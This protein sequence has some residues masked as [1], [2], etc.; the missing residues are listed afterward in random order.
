MPEILILEFAG[1]GEDVYHAVNAQLGIDPA[2]RTGDLPAGLRHHQAGTTA[3]G[4]LVV[5]E[6]WDSQEANT[7]FMESRLGP[8]LGQAG[9]PEPVRAEWVPTIGVIEPW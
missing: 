3:A 5:I 7:A 4:N 9:V 1:I 8:A 2:A 6:L